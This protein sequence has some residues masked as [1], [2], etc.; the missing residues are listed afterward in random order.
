MANSDGG[1]SI[2]RITK[3]FFFRRLLVRASGIVGKPILLYEVAKKSMEKANKDTSFKGMASEGLA[4]V[5][6][7]GRLIVAYA[8]G[9]YRDVSRKN[10]ILT[11][12]A[13]LYFVSPLDLIPDAIPLIGYLDDITVIGWVLSMIGEELTKFEAF[14][15]AVATPGTGVA[16]RS[17]RELFDEATRRDLPGREGMSRDELSDALKGQMA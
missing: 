10:V 3:S 4:S 7:F 14:E 6:R 1:F 12:A 15:N 16:Q 5:G 11:V 8:K 17:Y 9:D 13:L 2:G